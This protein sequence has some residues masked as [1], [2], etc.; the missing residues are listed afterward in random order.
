MSGFDRDA[1]FA[2]DKSGLLCQSREEHKWQGARATLGAA[3]GAAVLGFGEAGRA[4][5]L[6]PYW[7]PLRRS[8]NIGPHFFSPSF[9]RNYDEP[10]AST[11]LRPQ[12]RTK[13]CAAWDGRRSA[14][15]WSSVRFGLHPPTCPASDAVSRSL[16]LSCC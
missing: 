5:F 4:P 10:Q 11:I 16:C 14:P 15:P 12:S 9:P 6:L 8:A 13:A 1:N 2:I 3:R 7:P